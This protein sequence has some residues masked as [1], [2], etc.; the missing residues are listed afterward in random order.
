MEN[1]N[2]NLYKYIGHYFYYLAKNYVYIFALI[3]IGS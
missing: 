1:I 3:L 2:S